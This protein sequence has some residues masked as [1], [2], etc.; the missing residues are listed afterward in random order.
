M[1]DNITPEQ[2]VIGLVVSLV[3]FAGLVWLLWHYFPAR[4]DMSSAPEPPTTSGSTQVVHVPVPRTGTAEVVPIST[5]V[6]K[7]DT[8]AVEGGTEG[9][10]TPR[11][12]T[13]LSDTEMIALLASQRGKDGKH[14][15]SANQI[16]A[17]VGGSR[18]D[19]LDQ[20]KALRADAPPVFRPLDEQ[21]RAVL[22]LD[23]EVSR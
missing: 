3:V 8:E 20:V 12:S 1:Y 15:Y 23:K 22:E 11:L 13:R 6:E 14:R 10:E 19:V 2:W 5:R 21:R 16:H 18:K 4:D 17:L 7:T 9:W